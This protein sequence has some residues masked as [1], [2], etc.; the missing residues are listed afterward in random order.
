MNC[1][2]V[3]LIRISAAK[4]SV[5]VNLLF[6]IVTDAGN[7]RLAKRTFSYSLSKA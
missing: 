7:D 2:L 5:S 6:V 3:L 1:R 4:Q